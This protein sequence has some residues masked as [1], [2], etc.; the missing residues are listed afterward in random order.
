MGPEGEREKPEG[1]RKT[2]EGKRETREGLPMAAAG[3]VA[4]R[5]EGIEREKRPRAA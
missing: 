3:A 1:K 5:Q 2:R 4:L